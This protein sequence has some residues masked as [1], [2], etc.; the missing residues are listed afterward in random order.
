MI[1]TYVINCSVF[2]TNK[3][4]GINIYLIHCVFL[5]KGKKKVCR[6]FLKCR[7]P[8]L[9]SSALTNY[10]YEYTYAHLQA[11]DINNCPVLHNTRTR[12]YIYIL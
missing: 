11:A 4:I 9:T 5:M 2:L 6:V 12:T 8:P 1:S 3:L 10:V 7:H